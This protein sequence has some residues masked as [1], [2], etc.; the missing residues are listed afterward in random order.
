MFSQPSC[1]LYMA[2][3]WELSGSWMA[4]VDIVKE[5]REDITRFWL[6]SYI[7]RRG[8]E[9]GG[10]GLLAHNNL[11]AVVKYPANMCGDRSLCWLAMV[12][13]NKNSSRQTDRHAKQS[14]LPT[15]THVHTPSSPCHVSPDIKSTWLYNKR[16]V[17]HW[18]LHEITFGVLCVC[19]HEM[20]VCVRETE[21]GG[22]SSSSSSAG[23]GWGP[24]LIFSGIPLFLEAR[25]GGN[26]ICVARGSL[27]LENSPHT[28]LCRQLWWF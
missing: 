4:C 24:A 10:G 3:W 18:W 20:C 16:G 14:V 19:C 12:S 15:P 27:L 22:G 2:A 1:N 6:H 28:S 5:T 8:R 13:K 21:K 23:L 26:W 7:R 11:E 9:K 25:K 17:S